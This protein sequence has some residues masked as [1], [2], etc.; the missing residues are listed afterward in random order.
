MTGSRRAQHPVRAGYAALAIGGFV[1]WSATILLGTDDGTLAIAA[2]VAPGAIALAGLIAL[3]LLARSSFAALASPTGALA[4]AITIYFGFGALIPVTAPAVYREFEQNLFPYSGSELL[5]AH[6][7]TAAGIMFLALSAWS[8]LHFISARAPDVGGS[9]DVACL[10]RSA[11]RLLIIGTGVRLFVNTPRALGLGTGLASGSIAGLEMLAYVGL[12]MLGYGVARGELKRPGDRFALL[13]FGSLNLGL[14][15]ISLSKLSFYLP[16]GALIAGVGLGRPR[17]RVLIPA[18]TL[19]LLSYFVL[20]PFVQAGRALRLDAG[21]SIEERISLV[22]S[23]SSVSEALEGEYSKWFS[24]NRFNYVK[25]TVFAVRV[26]RRTA[27]TFHE[28]QDPLDTC[29]E[30]RLADKTEHVVVG[31]GRGMAHERCGR[32]VHRHRD[33][34]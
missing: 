29:P 22:P 7:V 28:R 18:M 34:W 2:F 4:F 16:V 12:I 15:L 9:V 27:W 26:R 11:M 25:E 30:I 10:R 13:F 21:E 19:T 5:A 8:V 32:R 31:A 24:L 23:T 17:V 14:G 33:F 1:S 20:Q 6:R 3:G